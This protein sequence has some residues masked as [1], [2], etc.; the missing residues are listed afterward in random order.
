[1]IVMLI[2]VYLFLSGCG[3]DLSNCEDPECKS[4]KGIRTAENWPPPEDRASSSTKTSDYCNV[5]LGN[6]W[7]GD[8]DRR[9]AIFGKISELSCE[10]RN[11]F[12]S[13]FDVKDMED[14][15]EDMTPIFERHRAAFYPTPTDI[16]QSSFLKSKL[17]YL[18]S[19]LKV[20]KSYVVTTTSSWATI[21]MHQQCNWE[22]QLDAVRA[23]IDQGYSHLDV[24][25]DSAK[26]SIAGAVN[27]P[28][29]EDIQD[30]ITDLPGMP[31][32]TIFGGSRP[33]GYSR[34]K[35][36]DITHVSSGMAGPP[37]TGCAHTTT[38][39]SCYPDS[40]FVVCYEYRCIAVSRFSEVDVSE[41]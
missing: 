27:P 21:V 6:N 13:N 11:I 20:C 2:L 25:V 15:Y 14:W 17:P 31:T 23:A 32:I 22:S 19:V 36:Q 33:G 28:N 29:L 7:V 30:L 41:R 9:Q 12:Y 39:E 3:G 35:D 37:R 38:T 4:I 10:V 34:D 8:R 1:M 24:V 16:S 18:Q 5:F 40:S 26:S